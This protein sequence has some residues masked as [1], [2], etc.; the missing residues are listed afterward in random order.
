M[1]Y[2]ILTLVNILTLFSLSAQNV[3]V[4]LGSCSNSTG[5]STHVEKSAPDLSF[6]NPALPMEQRVEILLRQLTL[7]EKLAM[8]E[9]QNPAIERLG[10]PAYSWWNEA[11]HGVARNGYATVYPQPIG[12]AATFD[13]PAVKQMFSWIAEEGRWKFEEAQ[14]NKEYG[15]YKGISFFTPN[16]NIFRDP[17][18]GRGMETYG[19]DP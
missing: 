9:H 14:R 12:L 5:A 16:I 10:I 13:V 7:D 19:E 2:W 4:I 6:R 15:D 11:L 18:W 1:K 8:M 17:R 3:G